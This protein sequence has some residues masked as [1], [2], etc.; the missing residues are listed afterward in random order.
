[1]H[2]GEQLALQDAPGAAQGDMPSRKVLVIEDNV[3]A[4]ETL[5]EVL[6]AWGH[7]VE[8]AFDGR[9]G[10]EKARTFRPEIVLCDI[11][12]PKMDG[13]EVARAIRSDSAL[14]STYLVAVTGYATAEDQREAADA[15]FDRHIAKPASIDAIEE[16][17]AGDPAAAGS[18]A[19]VAL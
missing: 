7:S 6:L 1:M 11:G 13:Y 14:A 16:A 4:A 8:I 2:P 10:L 9:S 19:R 5:R 18:E 12:L 3:D 15:G 17:L